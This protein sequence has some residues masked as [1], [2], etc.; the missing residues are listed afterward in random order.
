MRYYKLFKLL[1]SK[2]GAKVRFFVSEKLHIPIEKPESVYL[3]LSNKCNFQCAMCDQ[4][5]IGKTEKKGDYLKMSELRKFIDELARWGISSFGISGGET[6]LW[7]T[8]VLQLLDYANKKGLYTHFVTNGFLLDEETIRSY[9]KMGGG[10]ISLSLD[11]NSELHDRL[12]GMKGAYSAVMR[13]IKEF[14]TV[15]AKNILLK[16]N[17]VITELN[18]DEIINVVELCRKK[19]LSI[20]LQPF[21]PYNWDDRKTITLSQIRKKY[22]LWVSKNSEKKLHK[23]IHKLI[24]I[25]KKEPSLVLNSVQHLQAIP[26]YFQLKLNRD[27]CTFGFRALPISPQGDIILCRYGAIGN[28]KKISIKKLWK[29]KKYR[30]ARSKSAKCDYDC[31][32]G[33]MY[34]PSIYSWIRS[35][36]HL[37]KKRF[38]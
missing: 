4:W 8:K 11:A 23:V 1:L 18:I 35:G 37:V 2:I 25:K 19:G 29:S 32:I 17:L 20:F 16:I 24:K 21:D 5:K 27:Y 14:E 13:A 3:N 34:D 12:R 36:L 30:N 33:C 10:H 28:I 26:D 31:L 38:L 9:D 7:K 15:K 22:P 6:L